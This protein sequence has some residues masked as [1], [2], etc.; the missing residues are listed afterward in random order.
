IPVNIWFNRLKK[1]L[2]E[3]QDYKWNRLQWLWR[4]QI[5][6]YYEEKSVTE[7][8]KELPEKYPVYDGAIWT[9]SSSSLS[10]Y[11]EE[12]KRENNFFVKNKIPL[13]Y[14][15]N[16]RISLYKNN[17]WLIIDI[18]CVKDEL[19]PE[20]NT[21][22]LLNTKNIVE[23]MLGKDNNSLGVE[24]WPAGSGDSDISSQGLRITK[25]KIN[26][27]KMIAN[28]GEPMRISHIW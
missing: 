25:L 12:S 4:S 18:L 20:L 21:I 6:V 14:I 10:T 23:Y 27:F 8:I 19:P 22:T 7:A 26:N 16:P 15:T 3:D 2:W 1:S 5:P 17:S 11:R 9:F 28:Y 24:F 13:F